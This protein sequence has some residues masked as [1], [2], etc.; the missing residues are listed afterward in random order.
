MAYRGWNIPVW[1]VILME[2]ALV[3]VFFLYY[4][5]DISNIVMVF[6][7]FYRTNTVIT[8]YLVSN[9]TYHKGGS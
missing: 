4:M 5:L 6:L 1:Q 7:L 3:M 2:T 8:E 9:Y